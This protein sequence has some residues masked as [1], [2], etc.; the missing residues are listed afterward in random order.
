MTKR[1][2]TKKKPG[3]PTAYREE[4]AA[5]AYNLCL[6]GATNADL[7]RSFGVV[8][9]TIDNWIASIPEF[10][11]AIKAGR[12]EADAKVAKRLYSRACGYEHKAVKIFAD[13]KTG[14]EHVVE[15]IERYPPDTVAAI[16]WL[17]NRR[18]A[19]WRE[20]QELDHNVKLADIADDEL[21]GLIATLRKA[22]G[23]AGGAGG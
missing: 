2:T 19:Q 9:A 20:K 16:F 23:G 17:K 15:Y 12:E 10:L 22:A 8:E 4:F 6:L 21:A 14:A 7:A 5:Q 13:A 11:G 1:R 18:P 3:R